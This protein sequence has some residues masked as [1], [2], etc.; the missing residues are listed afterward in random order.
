MDKTEFDSVLRGINKRLGVSE[1]LLPIFHPR[2][3]SFCNSVSICCSCSSMFT[4][5]G[6]HGYN[7][8]FRNP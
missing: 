4:V 5:G 1:A 8:H 2:Q 7:Q 3:M 6:F